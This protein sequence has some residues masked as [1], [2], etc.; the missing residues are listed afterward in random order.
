M[1]QEIE[2]LESQQIMTTSNNNLSSFHSEDLENN[3][4]DVPTPKSPI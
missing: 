3:N 4:I 2:N 1:K